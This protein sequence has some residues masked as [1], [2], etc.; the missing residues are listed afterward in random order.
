MVN[1]AN[2]ILVVVNNNNNIDNMIAF[3]NAIPKS[4]PFVALWQ[5]EDSFLVGKIH[6]FMKFTT[7]G[8]DFASYSQ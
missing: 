7:S 5:H 2:D 4:G 3:A 6:L 8:K 1:I